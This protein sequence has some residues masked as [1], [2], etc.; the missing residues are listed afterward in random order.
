[1]CYPPIRSIPFVTVEE[2]IDCLLITV[3][4]DGIEYFGSAVNL[5]A[6]KVQRLFV[7]LSNPLILCWESIEA[8]ECVDAFQY[9]LQ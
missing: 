3:S 4:D 5:G 8:I 9:E 2:R 6:K 7:V 1:L